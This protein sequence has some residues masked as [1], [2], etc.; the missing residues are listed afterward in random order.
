MSA[1]T[2]APGAVSRRALIRAG[3]LM[4]LSYSRILGANDRIQVGQIGCGHRAVGHRRM[5]KLSATTDPN[6]T[7]RSVCDL[8]SVNRERA[9]AHAH[10]LFGTRPETYKYS[11][12]ILAD[13]DLDA[14]MIGTGDHQHA[15]L[16]AEV[17]RAGKDCYCEKPMANTL[18]DAKLA[19]DTVRGSKQIVQMG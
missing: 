2:T 17:V 13:K 11:E 6:F 8:W 18:D 4:A 15:R 16:L 7:L 12:E 1:E 19:R 14:V 5:L 10:D 3:A 9:A